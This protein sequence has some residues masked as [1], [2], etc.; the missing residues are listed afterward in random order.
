MNQHS[1]TRRQ[2]L[3][4]SAGAGLAAASLGS[5]N[6]PALASHRPAGPVP[7]GKAKQCIM[8][9]LGG[10][11]AQ[12]DT[13]DPKRKGD[14]KTRKPGSYYDNI[15][16]VLPGV[17]VCQHLPKCAKILDRFNLIRS[18]HHDV[19]DEHAAAT[20]RMHT[21]R[22]T[23][24]TVVYPSIGSVVA[25]QLGPVSEAAPGYVLIGYPNVTRG[26]GFLGAEA[27][28]VYLTDTASGPA[29][30]SR[31]KHITAKRQDRREQLL[32]QLRANYR[33]RTTGGRTIEDY[34]AT[35][36]E[37]L[38]LSGPEFSSVFQLD[39]E[40]DSVREA[41]G[42]E[43][44]QRC[45]LSRRLLQAGVR[46]VEVSH[47][48]S[49]VNGTGWDTHNE[50][51]LNQH[52]MIQEL[53]DALSALVLDLEKKQM[54]DETLIVVSTEFGRPGGFDSGGGRNHYSKAF[55][56]VMAGGGL[57]NGKVIGATNEVAE[58]IVDRPVSVPDLFATIHATLGIDPYENLYAGERPVPIT[59]GG[60]PI[61]ELF[62]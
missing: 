19:I 2:F 47:N 23:A 21:G 5:L 35:V 28:Y 20:N 32:A 27:G 34:D 38:R 59:D 33:Q 18:V 29:G 45:L 9:W 13:W 55:T 61:R 30:L 48:M 60:H 52:V 54:L 49:F 15:D 46:F 43:F 53:D 50:G 16:T 44:G 17:Q 11:A 4:T 24:G 40:P 41:Y 57:Q 62:S 25:H 10:G 12:I 1:T 14:A 37:A 42:G 7:Q 51:Q 26:P 6:L 58:V 36:A 8:V 3:Q 39:Q 31:A 56:V 22:P